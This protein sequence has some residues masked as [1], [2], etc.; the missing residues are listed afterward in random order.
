MHVL[1]YA[2]EPYE[3]FTT[4]PALEEMRAALRSVKSQFGQSYP[5]VIG[6][7][8]LMTNALLTSTNPSAPSEVVGHSARATREHADAALE[9]AWTAFESWKLWK[10]EDRSRVM[11]KAAAIMRR[12]KRELEAWLVYEIG[13][14]FVEASAEVAE[15]I[16]FTEYYARQ[17]M[18][19]VGGLGHLNA[20]SGEEN[21]SFHIPLGAGLTIAP[22]NFRWR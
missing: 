8:K 10:Q 15:M 16:D 11:L 19:H 21:E 6:G 9:A 17:A 1:S 4:P 3:T 22:W 18:R 14:N 7:K 2:N 20:C 12:R 5:M 13:K